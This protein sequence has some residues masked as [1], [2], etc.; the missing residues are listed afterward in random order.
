MVSPRHAGARR[1]R[2][3]DPRPRATGRPRLPCASCASCAPLPAKGARKAGGVARTQ[4]TGTGKPG[5]LSPAASGSA[6]SAGP[7]AP[8]L[9]PPLAAT[10]LAAT[11]LAEL[12]PRSVPECPGG[13]SLI[14]GRGLA[15]VPTRRTHPGVVHLAWSIWRGPSGVVHL[16]PTPPGRRP[17][18]PLPAA[19]RLPH[20]TTTVVLFCAAKW[21]GAR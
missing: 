8:P 15:R 13:A 5:V 19:W 12:I 14:V 2:P 16:A 9:A 11:P 20:S 10:P 7:L 4:A 17:A 18:L 21:V 1:S 6:G 3:A